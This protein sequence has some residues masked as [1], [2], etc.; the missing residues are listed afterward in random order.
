MIY[1]ETNV[2]EEALSRIRMLFDN[3]DDIVVSMSGGKDSTVVFQLALMV[4]R[5]KGR[6]PLKV[7]WLDQE[8]EWQG[9]VDYMS[10]I[11]H[12]PEVEPYWYQIPFDFPN[13][14]SPVNKTLKIW[15]DEKRDEWIHPLSD[16]GIHESPI[17]VSNV[18]R[19]EA[20]YI[21]IK[22]LPT[23]IT[24]KN[25]A[26]LVGMRMIESP[27]RR[28]AITGGSARWHGITWCTTPIGNTRKF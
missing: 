21:L 23:K 1:K 8:A 2:F 10:E 7:F 9:T 15:D 4:A 11:M 19:D 13:N 27:T 25:C 20:F 6:L 24:S 14:L 16:I 18:G 28:I 22:Q 17:D 12:M 26:V 5:E 3:H